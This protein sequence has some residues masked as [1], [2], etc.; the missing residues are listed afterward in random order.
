MRNFLTLLTLLLFSISAFSEEYTDRSFIDKL[1]LVSDKEDQ[2]SKALF[3]VTKKIN[4]FI[5]R[6][7]T[8]LP[9][10][11]PLVTLKIEGI[12]PSTDTFRVIY[13]KRKDLNKLNSLEILHTITKQLIRRTLIT[14]DAPKDVKVPDWL[15][16]GYVYQYMVGETLSSL[17][18]YP[19]SRQ[20]IISKKFPDIDELL[21][22]KGPDPKNFW[23]YSIYAERAAVFL[24]GLVPLSKGKKSLF[25]FLIEGS[26]K[27]IIESFSVKF[28]EFK[29][30]RQRNLW[31]KKACQ[32]ICF[33]VINPYPPEEIREKVTR[34]LSV[35]VARPGNNGFGTMR[36]PLEDITDDT[37]KTIDL[38]YIALLERSLLEISLT[39]SETVR[40]SLLNFLQSLQFLKKKQF[41]EFKKSIKK[42]KE[43]FQQAI[44]R[45][46]KLN[47][48]LDELEKKHNN[49]N[50]DYSRIIVADELAEIRKKESFPALSLYLEELE[51]KLAS[52]VIE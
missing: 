38:N 36:T 33:N 23:L 16:A 6:K 17:E 13:F 24:R 51:K 3:A 18:K 34:L 1:Q 45:Q 10:D 21:R 22:Q 15:I 49:V 26:D 7:L 11:A 19:V 52:I 12:P 14:F 30:Q 4:Q 44:N 8:K 28:D 37:S 50:S 5:S 27:S 40:P 9:G 43:K 29:T 39:S 31:F 2:D 47:R 41:D 35:T 20:A 46:E 25:S 42:A 48:Y 32:R